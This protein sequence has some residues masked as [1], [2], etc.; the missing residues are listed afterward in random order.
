M[1]V[2]SIADLIEK[3]P[4]VRNNIDELVALCAIIH[5]V[6]L[7]FRF[8]QINYVHH[9]P[10]VKPYGSEHGEGCLFYDGPCSCISAGTDELPIC[11]TDV[12]HQF[13]ICNVIYS[14]LAIYHQ[15]PWN[16]SFP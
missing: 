13:L 4:L 9:A 8:Q 16:N 15:P 6:V 2:E 5:N 12:L 7:I 10:V 11:V 3:D 14:E 1:I